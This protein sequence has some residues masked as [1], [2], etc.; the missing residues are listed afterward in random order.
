MGTSARAGFE[1]GDALTQPSGQSSARWQVLA[2]VEDQ[3]L[4]VAQIAR[5]LGLTRQG[6]QRVADL[7]A[8]EHLVSYHD[9]PAHRR[10]KLLHLQ[11]QGKTVLHD[12]QQR[13]REWAN[14]VSEVLDEQHLRQATAIVQTVQ[15]ALTRTAD[16]P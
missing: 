11:D 7:L 1:V 5:R 15:Q 10:A 8:R 13:Q 3:P 2:A 14:R 12:I 6:V 9:N 4:T 16:E